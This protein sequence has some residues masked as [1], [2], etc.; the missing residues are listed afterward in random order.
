MLRTVPAVTG[1]GQFE[2]K[3]MPVDTQGIRAVPQAVRFRCQLTG[4][5]SPGVRKFQG[6]GLSLLLP[7]TLVIACSNN[8]IFM[9][10]ILM[11]RPAALEQSLTTA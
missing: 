11:E 9:E 8:G 5:E 4:K 7:S 1:G 10:F 2:L 6:P 3:Q